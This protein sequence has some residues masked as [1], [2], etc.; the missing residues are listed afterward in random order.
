MAGWKIFVLV[1]T[2]L[3]VIG[4][5]LLIW[6]PNFC[7]KT[8][9]YRGRAIIGIIIII[10]ALVPTLVLMALGFARQDQ[11]LFTAGACVAVLENTIAAVGSPL[12]NLTS[13]CS[14]DHSSSVQFLADLSCSV[15]SLLSSQ[16]TVVSDLCILE[17]FCR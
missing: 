1:H 6:F 17:E 15:Q 3:Q 11:H 7:R 13:T 5:W 2:I 14:Q 12:F 9:E 16:V 4:G 10:V 8:Y